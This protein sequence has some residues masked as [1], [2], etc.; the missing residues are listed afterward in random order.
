V[1]PAGTNDVSTCDDAK[2]QLVR[3][4]VALSAK[5]MNLDRRA[6]ATPADGQAVR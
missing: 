6:R 4:F 3:D 5:L 2:E 1:A